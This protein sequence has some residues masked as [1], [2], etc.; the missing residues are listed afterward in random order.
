MKKLFFVILIPLILG[1]QGCTKSVEKNAENFTATRQELGSSYLEKDLD[2]T[3]LTLQLTPVITCYSYSKNTTA[4]P[5]EILVQ[6]NCQLSQPLHNYLR[7]QIK[8]TLQPSG[9]LLVD[10]DQ[11]HTDDL[12]IMIAPKTQYVTLSSH[13]VNVSTATVSNIYRIGTI[14]VLPQT[15]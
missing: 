7:I 8:R 9:S 14:E 15:R 2:S 4:K 1:M 3:I 13:Y 5:C 10:P 12:I 6:F 11:L